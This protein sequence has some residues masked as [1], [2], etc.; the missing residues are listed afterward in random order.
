V[1]GFVRGDSYEV[2]TLDGR[3]VSVAL[4]PFAFRN[5]VSGEGMPYRDN[6][7]RRKGDLTV[8]LCTRAP[9]TWC[10][11][12]PSQSWRLTWVVLSCVLAVANWADVVSSMQSWATVGM[13]LGGLYL[14]LTNSTLFIFLGFILMSLRSR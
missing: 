3:R 4:A 13:Y 14:F 7:M 6:G 1:L 8:H 9:S 2:R 10:L 11:Q 12:C 5:V